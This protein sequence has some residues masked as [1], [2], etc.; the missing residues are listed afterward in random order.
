MEISELI[1]AKEIFF[2]HNKIEDDNS[3]KRGLVYARCAFAMAFRSVAGP[4]R[5]G[6]IL[7][8]DHA[9]IVHYSKQ[10]QSLL[11]YDDYKEL[12][13]AAEQLRESLFKREDLPTMTHTDLIRIIKNLRNE[14]RIEKEKCQELYLYKEKFFKL[15]ELI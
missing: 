5:M 14:L 4:S 13:Q 15:K 9:S 7:G 3:R 11:N 1:A 6:Q 2:R 12:F 10:H 8:R